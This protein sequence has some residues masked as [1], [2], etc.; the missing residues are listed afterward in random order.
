MPLRPLPAACATSRPTLRFVALE[1]L[2]V[3]S[4]DTIA[5]HYRGSGVVDV[6]PTRTLVL[7]DRFVDPA[8][9][10]L[11]A[12]EVADA[13]RGAYR[14]DAHELVIVVT[15]RDMY[16]R[17]VPW[18]WA[19]AYRKDGVAVV[20]VARMDP[21]FPWLGASTYRPERPECGVALQARAHKMIT[22][23][24][25]FAACDAPQADDPRSARRAS[26]LSL[27]DLDAIDESVY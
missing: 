10:Q 5:D 17:T 4:V 26:V 22:R 1:P 6:G 20:S 12:E 21:S 18:H 9:D 3:L 14:P 15:D 13:A 16:L 25:L 7:Q 27:Q 11:V 8:R 24:I 19:F 23:Q 2:R